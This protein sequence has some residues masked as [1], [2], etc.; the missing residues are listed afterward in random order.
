[1][2]QWLEWTQNPKVGGVEF[3][4]RVKVMHYN[5]DSNLT[6]YGYLVLFH[7]I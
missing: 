3:G 1:M 6:K 7:K 4:V 5:R 2:C